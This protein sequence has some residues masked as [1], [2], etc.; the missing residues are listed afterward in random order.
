MS[1]TGYGASRP[2][3]ASHGGTSFENNETGAP[4]LKLQRG[5]AAGFRHS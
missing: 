3:C 4:A 2:G 5:R 1:L